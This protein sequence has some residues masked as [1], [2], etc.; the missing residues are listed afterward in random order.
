LL[1]WILITIWILWFILPERSSFLS[2]E[3]IGRRIEIPPV[4][5]KCLKT[6]NIKNP[7][8]NNCKLDLEIKV[9]SKGEEHAIFIEVASYILREIT[10]TWNIANS[11]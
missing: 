2:T 7:Q 6:I 9:R 4:K 8:Y 11:I 1:C 10:L 5:G 3:I